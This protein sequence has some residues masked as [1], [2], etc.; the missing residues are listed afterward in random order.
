MEEEDG[1][2]GGE[3]DHGDSLDTPAEPD[4]RDGELENRQA[5]VEGHAEES[6]TVAEQGNGG[7]AQV[8]ENNAHTLEK[9]KHEDGK[10]AQEAAEQDSLDIGGVDDGSAEVDAE[11]EI[12]L[13]LTRTR[14]PQF[15]TEYQYS[16]STL[17]STAGAVIA[18]A[19]NAQLLH[20]PREALH[21]TVSRMSIDVGDGVEEMAQGGMQMSSPEAAEALMN[22]LEEEAA[23]IEEAD[24]Q[25]EAQILA[26]ASSAS[27]SAHIPASAPADSSELPF[28]LPLAEGGAVDVVTA[29]LP[30]AASSLERV[31][32]IGEPVTDDDN[33]AASRIIEDEILQAAL[34]WLPLTACVP[35]AA[36]QRL[37]TTTELQPVPFCS[38]PQQGESEADSVPA[39]E[40]SREPQFFT[41][42]TYSTEE[43]AAADR[44]RVG[45]Q[46]LI[47]DAVSN[48]VADHGVDRPDLAAA[49]GADA[50]AE[51]L[52]QAETARVR[53]HLMASLARDESTDGQVVRWARGRS[54]LVLQQAYRGHRSRRLLAG[55]AARRLGN[56]QVDYAHM[57]ERL[58]HDL[59]ADDDP[60]DLF[61]FIAHAVSVLRQLPHELAVGVRTLLRES[62]APVPSTI[63]IHAADSIR[64]PRFPPSLH[65]YF[66]HPSLPLALP[67]P[68]PL[69]FCEQGQG[70]Q[71][72]GPELALSIRLLA[73]TMRL[74]SWGRLPLSGWRLSVCLSWCCALAGVRGGAAKLD[75]RCKRHAS[76]PRQQAP[77]AEPAVG[78][79]LTCK[80]HKTQRRRKTRKGM[81]VE[82]LIL[83]S[84]LRVKTRIVISA[85]RNRWRVMLGWLGHT[86]M[87]R[88][89]QCQTR[90]SSRLAMSCC[91]SMELCRLTGRI[92]G[93]QQIQTGHQ[94]HFPCPMRLHRRPVL[95]QQLQASATKISSQSPCRACPTEA[96]LRVTKT[97]KLSS[98]SIRMTANL[99][100][101][102]GSTRQQSSR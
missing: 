102:C 75:V 68:L 41:E 39:L 28:P 59:E 66:P 51:A 36:S 38:A 58:L 61:E 79:W 25:T 81:A 72:L 85:T 18:G 35:T 52:L 33:A 56:E 55:R 50:G 69:Y 37:P 21:D 13:S 16:T 7:E 48:S 100:T 64:C 12:D 70:W 30:A 94:S 17:D 87:Q 83:R 45:I 40:S 65:L 14:T 97:R 8:L 4:A 10:D 92:R 42:Y 77:R 44:L 93:L 5:A 96:C 27:P 101:S 99:Q 73:D 20:S 11:P 1:D 19:V 23:R 95:C 62:P 47:D 84:I 34:R 26:D 54:A 67:P 57:S 76:R 86:Q 24:R 74:P 98:R 91:R 22:T 82:R 43:V 80:L 31:P 89:L 63:R 46:A 90:M 3:N 9:D 60:E 6:Q 49:A 88:G 32:S 29:W 78:P 15:H 2:R 71:C 53:H